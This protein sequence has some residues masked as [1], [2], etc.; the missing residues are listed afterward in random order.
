MALGV[1]PGGLAIEPFRK[2]MNK[3]GFGHEIDKIISSNF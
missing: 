1:Y 2:S 3:L